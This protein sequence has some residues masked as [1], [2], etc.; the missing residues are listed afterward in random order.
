MTRLQAQA[1]MINIV[2]YKKEKMLDSSE[3]HS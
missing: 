2:F 3:D 1:G